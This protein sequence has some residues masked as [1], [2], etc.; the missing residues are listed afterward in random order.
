MGTTR[1]SKWVVLPARGLGNQMTVICQRSSAKSDKRVV[2]EYTDK[3]EELRTKVMCHTP[4]SIEQYY[5]SLFVG[6]S[7]RNLSI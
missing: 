7:K 6:R 5:I 1:G 3:F 4:K 2:E